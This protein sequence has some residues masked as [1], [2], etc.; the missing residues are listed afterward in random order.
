MKKIITAALGLAASGFCAWLPS[1]PI[2]QISVLEGCGANAGTT[3]FSVVTQPDLN[4]TQYLMASTHPLFS[5]S[6]NLA[7][8]ATSAGKTVKI[9]SKNVASIYSYM[10]EGRCYESQSFYRIGAFN[11]NR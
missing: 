1:A 9:E 3:A 11:L 5:A 6:Q 2:Y 8:I 4:S 7:T 10:Y